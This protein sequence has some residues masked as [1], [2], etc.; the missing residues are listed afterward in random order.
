MA[1][2][3]VDN[4]SVEFNSPRGWIKALDQFTMRVEEGSYHGII[5]ESGSGKSIAMMAIMGLL[6]SNAR[7]SA[8]RLALNGED[9]LD[10]SHERRRETLYQDV[11]II[12]QEP[13][14]SLN[15]CFKIKTQLRET[16]K[17]HGYDS[18]SA[19]R[20]RSHQLLADVGINNVEAILNSYPH[21]LTA[22]VLQRVMIAI[23]LACDPKVLIADE[24]TTELPPT[25][26]YQMMMLLNDLVKQRNMA[27]IL[28]S[29]DLQLL[30]DS[31]DHVSIMYCS[32]IVEQGTNEVI[33][34]RARHP[35][36]LSIL[37]GIP[38]NW[39]FEPKTHVPVLKGSKPSPQNLPVGCYLGPRCEYADTKCVQAPQP[40]YDDNHMIRCH[41]PVGVKSNE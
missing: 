39:S 24:P 2:L 22:G 20:S 27:M 33:F 4:L 6:G 18:R 21:Q 30:R 26:A 36:T 28:I 14:N 8:D 16:L 3:Q 32:Q 38:V 23:A 15:P 12:F 19:C 41:F 11:S 1:L 17:G 29:H 40:K 25:E 9:I 7:V 37:S 34:N 13:K 31:A 5:G 35:Y 10:M